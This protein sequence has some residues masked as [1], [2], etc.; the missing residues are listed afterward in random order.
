MAQ[1]KRLSLEQQLYISQCREKW[2]KVAISTKSI[3]RQDIT[4]TIQSA[5]QLISTQQ[6]EIIFFSSPLAMIQQVNNWLE[7]DLIFEA[8]TKLG[9]LFNELYQETED[10]LI[11]QLG[12]DIYEDIIAKLVRP[13]EFHGTEIWRGIATTFNQKNR[14]LWNSLV[15]DWTDITE[16]DASYAS[17]LDFYFSVLNCQRSKPQIWQIYH[18]LILSCGWSLLGKKYCLICEKPQIIT[19]DERRLLHG[20]GKPAIEFSDGFSIYA[21]HQIILPEKYGKVHPS[22]W[23]PAW[24]L[25]E[26]N[27]QVRKA[28]IQGIGYQR[29][30]QELPLIELDRLPISLNSYTEYT[31]FQELN[32]NPK[33]SIQYTLFKIDSQVCQEPIILL[34]IT[35]YNTCQKGLLEVSSALINI[36]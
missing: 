31:Y 7:N 23:Q 6:P 30:S 11:E 2:E 15:N 20:E 25:T 19:W 1:R 14:L 26:T 33:V 34:L 17:L 36:Q 13:I 12:E 4:Q 32:Y 18:N 3:D 5:Y 10:A 28:L 16:I 24:L 9:D 35:D 8:E 27:Y 22:Q 29:I 21:Y